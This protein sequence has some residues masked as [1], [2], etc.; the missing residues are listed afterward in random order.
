MINRE[1][2]NLMKMIGA[3]KN[4]HGERAYKIEI[5]SYKTESNAPLSNGFGNCYKR[6]ILNEHKWKRDRQETKETVAEIQRKAARTAPAFS[7]GAYQYVTDEA[8]IKTLGRKV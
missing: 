1:T 3:L 8:D 6:D 7:K 4:K 5:P 2:R